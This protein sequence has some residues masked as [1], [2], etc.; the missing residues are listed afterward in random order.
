M[1]GI[2][3]TFPSVFRIERSPTNWIGSVTVEVLLPRSG[4]T[5]PAGGKAVAVFTWLPVAPAGTVPVSV[6][7]TVSPVANESP[8]VAVQI[9]VSG[10]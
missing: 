4:S 9:P 7:I 6:K 10:S 8:G 5:T 1:P 3:L 2:A